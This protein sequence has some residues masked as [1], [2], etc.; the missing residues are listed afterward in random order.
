MIGLAAAFYIY[1]V[2][3]YGGILYKAL[4]VWALAISGI[5]GG[6]SC[7]VMSMLGKYRDS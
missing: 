2:Y 3:T 7:I 1:Y 4:I 5:L 6:I